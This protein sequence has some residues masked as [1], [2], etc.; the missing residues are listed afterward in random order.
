MVRIILFYQRWI[1]PLKAPTCRFYPSCSQYA[2]TAI[3]TH[4][5]AKGA[6][7]SVKRLFRCHPLCA[8]GYDPVPGSVDDT[9]V[10]HS[11]TESQI[12]LSETACCQASGNQKS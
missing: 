4:G 3:E 2:I 10:S 7:L 11:N 12:T 8:G 1:S 5:A 9:D 6:L